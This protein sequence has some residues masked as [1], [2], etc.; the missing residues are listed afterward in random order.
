[1]N[2]HAL[3]VVLV[4]LTGL[5]VVLVGLVVAIVVDPPAEGRV[6]GRG[7]MAVAAAFAALV[8]LALVEAH[9]AR[10]RQVRS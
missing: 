8:V 7:V 4:A 2:R 1:M 3:A 9:Q 5:A 6:D 10:I